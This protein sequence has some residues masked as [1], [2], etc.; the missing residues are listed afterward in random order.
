MSKIINEALLALHI[1]ELQEELSRLKKSHG[2]QCQKGE[3][4]LGNKRPARIL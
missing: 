4:Q 1:K 2:K 3:Q